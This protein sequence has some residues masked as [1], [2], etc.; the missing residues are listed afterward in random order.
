MIFHKKEKFHF[1]DFGAQYIDN[2]FFLKNKNKNIEYFYHDLIENNKIV[3]EF[4]NFNNL[5]NIKVIHSLENV[6]KKNMILYIL[7]QLFSM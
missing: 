4:S 5:K 1:L 3:E 6:K 7:V 2:Y